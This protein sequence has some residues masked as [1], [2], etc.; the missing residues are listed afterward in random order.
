M[1]TSSLSLRDPRGVA[2]VLN[3]TFRLLRVRWALFLKTIFY[4][5]APPI[6]LGIGA[7]G[8]GILFL[9]VGTQDG[10]ISSAVVGLGGITGVVGVILFMTGGTLAMT[11]IL[12]VSILHEERNGAS[13]SIMDVWALTKS[14]FFGVLGLYILQ[15][16]A[17]FI[18][19]PI[20]FIPCLGAIAFMA[21]TVFI[22]VRVFFLALPIRVIESDSV[23]SAISRSYSLVENYFWET[24]GIFF[25]IYVVQTIVSTTFMLPFQIVVMSTEFHNL[26]LESLP[27]WILAGAA[28]LFLLAMVASVLV[29][30]IM[31][32]AATVQTYALKERKEEASVEARVERLEEEAGSTRPSEDNETPE[33]G[34]ADHGDPG[35]AESTTTG[36]SSDTDELEDSPPEND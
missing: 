21:W 36:E 19:V 2:D 15:M 23:F 29:S 8:I 22:M 14:H 10:G 30:G 33:L 18:F 12:A 6:L 16:L 13:V 34:E 4:F 17:L 1:S 31:Y 26:D 28:G 5:G 3:V 25:V 35:P 7:L 20:I 11:G 24:A 32:V 27:G 9:A